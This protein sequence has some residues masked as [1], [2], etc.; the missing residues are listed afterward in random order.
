MVYLDDL[1]NELNACRLG[2]FLGGMWLDTIMYADDLILISGSVKQMH[3]MLEKCAVSST[4]MDLTL[5][6]KINFCYC[7]DQNIRIEFTINNSAIPFAGTSFKYLGTEL[8]IKQKLL[9]IIP[10]KRIGK[11]IIASMS[12]CRNTEHLPL[13]VRIE[14]IQRKC[15]PILMNAL[16]RGMMTKNDM[17]RL[18]ISYRNVYRYIVR[19]RRFSPISDTMFFC[20]ANSL[21]FLV[22]RA[23]LTLFKKYLEKIMKTYTCMNVIR[24]MYRNYKVLIMLVMT[25]LAVRLAIVCDKMITSVYCIM[26]SLYILDVFSLLCSLI[27]LHCCFFRRN[28]YYYY[29]YYRQNYVITR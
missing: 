29:Y 16:D 19:V 3:N 7:T 14:L 25:G 20:G 5:N 15:V 9:C 24:S 2:C 8:G 22:D 10:D 18:T 11:F 21:E 26:F 1:L 4:N 6:A 17:H 23:L 12:V 28:R 13:S 27:Y